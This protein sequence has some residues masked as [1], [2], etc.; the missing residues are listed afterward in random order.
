MITRYIKRKSV[1]DLIFLKSSTNHCHLLSN[2]DIYLFKI[3]ERLTAMEAMEHPYF[4]PIVKD[5]GRMN[6][7]SSSP[8]PAGL[9]GAGVPG[10]G[11]G[12]TTGGVPNSPILSPGSTPI[13]TGQQNQA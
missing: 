1:N 6:A 2:L 8:T 7:I 9:A 3:Q 13:P 11:V 4:Y 5:Q 12:A 10:V